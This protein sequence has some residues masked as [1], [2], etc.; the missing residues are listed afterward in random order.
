MNEDFCPDN[1]KFFDTYSNIRLP[2]GKLDEDEFNQGVKDVIAQSGL[3]TEGLRIS[4]CSLEKFYIF[5]EPDDNE[6]INT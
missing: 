5:C 6:L 4:R 3:N 1:L 2:L